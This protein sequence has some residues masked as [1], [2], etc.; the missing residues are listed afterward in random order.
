MKIFFSLMESEILF[1]SLIRPVSLLE[2][3]TATRNVFSFIP[4]IMSSGKI[5]P[6]FIT[7]GLTYVTLNLNL[8]ERNFNVSR[9]AE[10]SME[11]DIICLF[12]ES[13][14]LKARP[15]IAK[16]FD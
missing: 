4:A 7:D 14:N 15:L 9:T 3:I 16:L 10:C 11:V 2:C 12:G 1:M 13:I 6:P 5:I 8:S